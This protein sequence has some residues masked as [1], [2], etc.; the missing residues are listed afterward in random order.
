MLTDTTRCCLPCIHAD[1]RQSAAPAA[2]AVAAALPADFKP[3]LQAM[4]DAHKA[5]KYVLSFLMFKDATGA[6]NHATA[7]VQALTQQSSSSSKCTTLAAA[8]GGKAAT[9]PRASNG[10]QP[11]EECLEKARKAARYAVSFLAFDDAAGGVK[12]LTEVV[13]LLRH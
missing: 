5:A 6:L 8:A 11:S 13:E 4:Q 1:T 2:S 12:S 3:S 10:F 9:A 7:G